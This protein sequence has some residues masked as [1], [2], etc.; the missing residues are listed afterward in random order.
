M[1]GLE[2]WINYE[3]WRPEVYG[4][5]SFRSQQLDWLEQTLAQAAPE[6]RRVLFYHEDFSN[7]LDLAALDVELALHGHIHSDNGSLNGPPWS[8][9]TD[10]CT[11]GACSFRLIRVTPQGLAP[12]ATQHACDGDPLRVFWDGPNDGS[13]DSLAAT[14][15]NGYGLD[16]PEALV[17]ARL[18]PGVE[19]VEIS[20][21]ELRQLLPLPDV[22]RVEIGI[23]LDADATVEVSV[24]AVQPWLE[25]PL[26]E[27]VYAGGFLTLRWEAVAGATAYRVESAS[28]PGQ[29]WTDATTEGA[30]VDGGWRQ[31]V[32]GGQRW[33]RVV[34]RR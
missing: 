26:V 18:S 10:Q 12:Q 14:V 6:Q 27:A 22:T 29:P 20:G 34:A 17:V 19:E 21:G 11:D 5:E 24:R 31:A 9:A 3:N 16:F 30:F 8:L 13:R 7:Q 32:S 15:V 2:A 25:A 33:Y 4:G 1:V 23:D 28:A